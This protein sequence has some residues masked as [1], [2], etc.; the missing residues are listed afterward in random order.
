MRLEKS[1]LLILLFGQKN[2]FISRFFKNYCFYS[3]IIFILLIP[4]M[5]CTGTGNSTI[6][7]Q[8]IPQRA[9]IGADGSLPQN[10]LCVSV[11]N[12]ERALQDKTILG[13]IVL[14]ETSENLFY[15][16]PL[17]PSYAVTSAIKEYLFSS[18][19]TV[20]GGMPFWDLHETTIDST[21]GTLLI[22][23]SIED[24]QI[25]CTSNFLGTSYES[26]VK[27]RVVF[28]DTKKKRI[29]FATT[30]EAASAMRHIYYSDEK[31]RE[32]MNNAFSSAVEKIFENDN[33]PNA[34]KETTRVSER[35]LGW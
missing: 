19:H 11:F 20:Y 22:G 16:R 3:C 8:Y 26:E 12:D 5:G 32:V 31:A 2:Y 10:T 21:C 4:I 18:G 7:L 33:L 35:T 1:C 6:M 27:L 29:L 17:L 13:K 9:Y 25:R 14:S 15:C 23:G 24:L 30:V 34:L 28:A